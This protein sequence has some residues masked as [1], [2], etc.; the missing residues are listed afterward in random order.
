VT[1]TSQE[2]IEDDTM[3][4]ISSHEEKTKEKQKSTSVTK[5]HIKKSVT[6]EK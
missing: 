3:E 6:E 4:V 5:K 2:T 1:T